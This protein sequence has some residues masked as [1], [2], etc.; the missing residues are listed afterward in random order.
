MFEIRIYRD[1]DLP[2]GAAIAIK[3]R[4]YVAGWCLKDEL[5]GYY[6]RQS[7][8]GEMAIAFIDDVPVCIV[9]HNTQSVQAFCRKVL[10]GRGYASQC[11]DLLNKA[12]ISAREGAKGSRSFWAK[13]KIECDRYGRW[14][15]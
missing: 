8:K 14:N 3:A 1:S 6:S 4:L 15:V 9:A 12:K 5:T 7:A 2:T 11:L 10:R 13:N